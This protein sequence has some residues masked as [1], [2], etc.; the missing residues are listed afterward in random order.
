MSFYRRLL[1]VSGIAW[2][3]DYGNVIQGRGFYNGRVEKLLGRTCGGNRK[4]NRL[5]KIQS[6]VAECQPSGNV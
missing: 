6:G 2:K 5:K 4:G 3:K 1:T